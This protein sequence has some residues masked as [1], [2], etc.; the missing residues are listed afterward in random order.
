MTQICGGNVYRTGS[1]FGG[2]FRLGK[3]K[4]CM[5]LASLLRGFPS[6]KF[7]VTWNHFGKCRITVDQRRIF[8]YLLVIEFLYFIDV[9][10]F[11]CFVLG[12]YF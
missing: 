12:V 4:H 2:T 9:V 6:Q 7:S 3:P 8:I 1:N 10:F 5:I 11:L